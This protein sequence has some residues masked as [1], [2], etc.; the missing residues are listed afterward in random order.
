MLPPIII[1]DNNSLPIPNIFWKN[2]YLKFPAFL[3]ENI[4]SELFLILKLFD[5]LDGVFFEF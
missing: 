5:P 2:K 3:W 4:L 1:F